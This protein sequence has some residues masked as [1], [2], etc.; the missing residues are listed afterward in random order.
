[1]T[2]RVVVIGATGHIGR[3]LCRE[4]IR[5]GNLVTVFSRS[6]D[7]AQHV[8]PGAAS[9]VAWSP[10]ALSEECT[11]HL[12]WADAVVYLAGG[13]L[14]DGRRRSRVEVAAESRRRT[15]RS[16]SRTGGRG[17]PC[18]GPVMCSLQTAWPHRWLSSAATS[19]DGSAP[20]G[21]GPRGS[22]STT[23]WGSSCSHYSRPVSTGRSISLHPSQSGLGSSP[24]PS[25]RRSAG[26]PG[27]RPPPRWP[28]WG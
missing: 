18:C 15:P 13:P 27:Y 7:R 12:E 10:A 17:H 3:P 22:T 19:A 24:A 20:A 11:G 1:M 23:P 14:L 6:P 2:Q 28:G 16:A 21:A 25:G 4:L 9:Y 8:V 26:A 5:A